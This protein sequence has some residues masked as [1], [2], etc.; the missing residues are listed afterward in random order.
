MVLKKF[1]V[2]VLLLLFFTGHAQSDTAIKTKDIQFGSVNQVGILEG[3]AGSYFLL[4]TINGLRIK[5]WFVGVGT[6]LDYYH[7]RSV[8]VFFDLRKQLTRVSIP[9]YVYGDVGV[10]FPWKKNTKDDWYRTEFSNGWYYDIGL[11]Y[12]FPLKQQYAIILSGGYAQKKMDENRYIVPYCINPPCAEI[13]EQY[14]YNFRRI[15]VKAG[16]SF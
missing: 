13:K 1:G 5:K 16:L 3:E 4:Q 14:Q 2:A 7:F 15:S 10:H 11:S 12:Q 8:P 9:L 6:G